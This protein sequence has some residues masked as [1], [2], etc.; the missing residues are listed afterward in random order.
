M[1]MF[2]RCL[3][4]AMLSKMWWTFTIQSMKWCATPKSGEISAITVPYTWIYSFFT[5]SHD[6][7]CLSFLTYLSVFTVTLYRIG[8]KWDSCS[9]RFMSPC[10]NYLY[11]E[12]YALNF[13]WNIHVT[14]GIGTL[15]QWGIFWLVRLSRWSVVYKHIVKIPYSWRYIWKWEEFRTT[16]ILWT[17]N[18]VFRKLLGIHH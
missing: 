9:Y 16:G 17:V 4:T 15:K 1:A 18:S 6:S 2:Y 12:S 14:V 7:L 13:P 3:N 5:G 8:P 10:C 11:F